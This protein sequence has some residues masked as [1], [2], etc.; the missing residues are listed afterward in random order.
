MRMPV[1]ATAI[2]H[3]VIGPGRAIREEKEIKSEEVGKE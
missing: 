3:C 2:Q 1:T